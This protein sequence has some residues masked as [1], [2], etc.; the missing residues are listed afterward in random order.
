MNVYDYLL[1]AAQEVPDR[2][3]VEFKGASRTYA[4]LA[5]EAR[6]I[7]AALR[8]NGARP[9]D[10]IAFMLPNLPQYVTALYGAYMVGANT[11]PMNV[12]LTP[13]EIRYLVDDSNIRLIFVFGMFLPAV[14]KAIEGMPSPPNIVVLGGP[15]GEHLPFESLLA[16]EDRAEPHPLTPD[17]TIMTIYTSG[18]TGKPKGAMIT[19][20]NLLANLDMLDNV[21]ELTP[22]DKMLCVLPLFHVFA[23]NGVLHSAIRKRVPLVV[24][25]KFEVA[26]AVKSLVED[27]ITFFAGVPT[28]YFYILKHA[29]LENFSFPRLRYC[30][31]GGA[32]MP[33][34]VMRQFEEKFDVMIT[35][36]FGLTETT[37]SV[38]MNRQDARK[39]GSIG[40]PFD[41]VQ[42]K[43]VD[44]NGAE[45]PDGEIGEIVIK[46]PNVMKGYLNKPEATA[47]AIKDGWFY[48]GDLGYRDDEGFF[49]VVDRKKDMIIKG[50]YNI[51]PR[52]IEEVLYQLPQ[53]AEAAVVG[54]FDE[55]KGEAVRAV[56]SFKP[57]QS[58]SEEAIRSHVEAN[59]AK[60][61]WPQDYMI[62]P[63]LPK[64]P[65]GKILKREIKKN[66]DQWNRDRVRPDAETAGRT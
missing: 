41:G 3:G 58:L 26:D 64:G 27:G 56:V 48:S 2:V 38:T 31:S 4:E 55:A 28:M 44:E 47:E 5:D 8:L 59:L 13:P 54:I 11:V 43:V 15:A 16:T 60:Y 18:T 10:S 46:A 39:P 42:M 7:A 57:G 6:R 1:S 12:L 34:D 22:D 40:L 66:W 50:G 23:L 45:V 29:E 17:D 36:G 65:T 20:A 32:A 35:E 63:E 61:K 21:M 24:H 37:V 14:E 49:Y 9:G 62:V 33:V 51:Y 19:N 53:V 52:E 30:V 25:T